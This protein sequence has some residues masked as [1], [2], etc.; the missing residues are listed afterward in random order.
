VN[1]EMGERLR[2]ERIYLEAL[3]DMKAKEKAA[4]EKKNP[5]SVI[6]NIRANLL[7]HT[8]EK[9]FPIYVKMGM[10]IGAGTCLKLDNEKD[11]VAT[12]YRHAGAWDVDAAWVNGELITES[13]ISSIDDRVLT[14]VTEEEWLNNNKGYV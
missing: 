9:S 12:Y 8:Y 11:G 6:D 7:R 4:Y 5:I 13:G 1:P 10:T 2:R 3:A 14:E